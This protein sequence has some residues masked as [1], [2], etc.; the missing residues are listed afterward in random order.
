MKEEGES[1]M[2]M[3]RLARLARPLAMLVAVLLASGAL[4]MGAGAQGNAGFGYGAETFDVFGV[5][6]EALN[7]R[8]LDVN[9]DTTLAFEADQ[10]TVRT[11]SWTDVYPV[12]LEKT[13]YSVTIRAKTGDFGLMGDLSVNA[14]GSLTA[15]E[16]ILDGPSRQF[17]F[18][19][20]ERLAG[21]KEIRDL[22]KEAPKSI[23]SRE[24]RSFSLVFSNGIGSYGLD[25]DWASGRYS[26][27]I[28]RNDAG[29][30]QMDFRIMGDSYIVM[31]Y[32]EA[33]SD[34]Y[35]KGLADLIV[36][37]EIPRLNG[38]Y[39]A[40][41]VDRDDYTLFIR[42]ASG[43]SLSVRAEGDAAL[44]CPFSIPA[45]LDYAWQAT[46]QKGWD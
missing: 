7:G 25:S 23:D 32:R 14:D 9:S 22:S 18:V 21:E 27:M 30:Y 12:H 29:G 35:V 45:L 33:V 39:R 5:E 31:D 42:Y 6:L 36:R 40:N 44:E 20:E 3:N 26:W 11:G 4:C 37:E 2:N 16:M 43:E 1:Q 8:W 13:D 28:E 46:G 34:E 15:Y 24:I 10:M 17:R 19:R 41:N 38:Y